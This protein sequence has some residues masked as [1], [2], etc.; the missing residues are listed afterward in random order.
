MKPLVYLDT[1]ILLSFW[2]ENDPYFEEC[3]IIESKLQNGAINGLISE[4][5]IRY[6]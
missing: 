5:A 3:R 1:N 4:I 6:C 2:S